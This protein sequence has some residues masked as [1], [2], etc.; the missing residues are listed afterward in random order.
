MV[1]I[2]S[3]HRIKSMTEA[4]GETQ[5]HASCPGE[6][7]DKTEAFAFSGKLAGY[8]GFI[9]TLFFSDKPL[10][11]AFVVRV[12]FHVGWFLYYHIFVRYSSFFSR[13]GEGLTRRADFFKK[14]LDGKVK[15]L[16]SYCRGYSEPEATGEI[17]WRLRR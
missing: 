9:D 6:S 8:P 13:A 7:I 10:I 5:G 2:V 16:Y 17:V 3:P 11:I 15:V 1:E 14:F 12:I 4:F